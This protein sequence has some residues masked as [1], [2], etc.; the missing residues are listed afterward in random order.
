MRKLSLLAVA[1]L[2]AA[3]AVS[4]AKT[5]DELLVEKGVVSSE[6]GGEGS[7][8][9]KGGSRLD[10]GEDFHMKVNIQLQPRYTFEDND[11]S[12]RRDAGIEVDEDNDTSGFSMRRARIVFSGH[13]LN[14]TWE[15]KLQN[16]FAS[17]SGG[18]DLKDAWLQWNLD[19]AASVRMGQYKQPFSRQELSSSAE[20]QFPDRSIAN[21]HFAPSRQQGVM[22]HGDMGGIEYAASLWNGES[23]GEG[24]NRGPEDNKLAGT[25]QVIGN[26]G[27]YGSRKHEGDIEMTEDFGAT[28]GG[29]VSYGQGNTAE[30]GDFDKVDVNVDAA[31]RMAGFSLQGEWYWS[32]QDFDDIPGDAGEREDTGGYVQGGFYFV[33]QEWEAAARWAYVDYDEDVSAIDDEMEV[34]VGLNYHIWK[35][36]LKIQNAVSWIETTMANP[37]PSGDD[38]SDL[39]YVLQVSGYF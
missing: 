12:G 7:T 8:H 17:D 31:L 21:E 37:G 28:M 15:Y 29:A 38:Y 16:D 25:V 26:I 18:G 20:L 34:T 13:M 10:F 30:G 5:L 24:R 14:K 4:E 39:R 22:M 2:L 36:S 9:Y 6:H 32:S 1:G 19:E 27:D 3:P 23:D 11:T 33:P 35:H